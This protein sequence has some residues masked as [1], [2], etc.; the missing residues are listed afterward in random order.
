MWE[1][2]SSK[3]GTNVNAKSYWRK[4]IETGISKTPLMALELVLRWLIYFKP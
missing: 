3:Y 4:K 1:Y 2:G